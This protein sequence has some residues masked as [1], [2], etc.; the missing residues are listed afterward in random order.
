MSFLRKLFRA[1]KKLWF[2]PSHGPGR[3]FYPFQHPYPLSPAKWPFKT[4]NGHFGPYY[5]YM[6][7]N[8]LFLLQLSCPF[9]ILAQLCMFLKLLR[10][11]NISDS[12]GPLLAILGFKELVFGVLSASFQKFLLR[13]LFWAPKNLWYNP[14]PG[15]GM[16][17]PL[18]TLSS[19][20]PSKWLFKPT[21]AI[22]GLTTRTWLSFL[23]FCSNWA[24]LLICWHNC[25]RFQVP[26]VSFKFRPFLDHWRP[27]WIFKE[28]V[29]GV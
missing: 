1:L 29:L 23:Y 3:D 19:L 6:I 5:Q 4:K 14:S 13:K 27:F 25:V 17:L 28:S 7:L 26:W 2:N 11:Q 22:L 24:V 15:P 16:G 12:F 18:L 9:N 8:S 10:F 20:S 21:T